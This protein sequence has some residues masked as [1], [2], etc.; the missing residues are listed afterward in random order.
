[1]SIANLSDDE[2]KS[3]LAD[4][5]TFLDSRTNQVK[6]FGLDDAATQARLKAHAAALGMRTDALITAAVAQA[7]TQ[8]PTIQVIPSIFG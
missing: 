4:P 7:V 8:I 1:M 2:L 6:I 3:F 5:K